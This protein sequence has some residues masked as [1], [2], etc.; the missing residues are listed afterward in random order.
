MLRTSIPNHAGQPP[1]CMGTRSIAFGVAVSIGVAPEAPLIL[2][3]VRQVRL[4]V[5][6][7]VIEGTAALPKVKAS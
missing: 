6:P 7:H 3:V 5:A 2:G 1:D 4:A